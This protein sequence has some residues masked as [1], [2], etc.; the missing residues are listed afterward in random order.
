MLSDTLVSFIR[1]GVPVVVG[2]VVAYLSKHGLDIDLDPFAAT[3]LAISLYYALVRALEKRW[4]VFGFLLGVPK[5]PAYKGTP[6]APTVT[7]G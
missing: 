5:E 3:A 6:G 7:G 2:A 4:P 1:T